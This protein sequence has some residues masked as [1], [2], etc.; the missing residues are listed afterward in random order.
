MNNSK[1]LYFVEWQDAI[2]M[3]SGWYEK[4]V[5][6]QWGKSESWL[7]KQVGYL[8]DEN[9]NYILLATKFNPQQNGENKF[10]EITKIP[11]SWVT[12]RKLIKL[13]NI[14]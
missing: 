8:I 13:N 9:E 1:H 11:K 12:K 3:P 14:L 7:I 2:T 5:C 4:D 6:K 10:S